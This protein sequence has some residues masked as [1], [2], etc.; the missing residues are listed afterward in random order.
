MQSKISVLAILKLMR[1][2][3]WIKN[4]FVLAPLIFAGLFTQI[5]SVI[6]ALIAML[7][8]CVGS[9]ATYVLNDFKDIENDKK[10]PTKSKTRPLAS[11][12]VS[13][14]QAKVLMVVLYGTVAAAYVWQPHIVLVIT[15]YLLLNIAYTFYL[16]YQPVLDIFTISIGFV[17]RV[18]AGA[19]ALNVPLSS[20]MFIT[21]L[22]LALYLAA[23]KR[24]QELA[25]SGEK[26]RSVLRYY[27][28]ELIDKY[29]E[30]SATCALLFYS[31]YVISD[32]PKMVFTIP[33]VL[34]GL[35]RYWYI[36][37]LNEEG[38]SPTDA[39]FRDTQIQLTI[40]SWIMVCG[41]ALSGI[42]L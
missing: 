36:V 31:L 32:Q 27:N 24:R 17:L 18:Y 29:A 3:Q 16:K 1:P 2:K 10:H 40:I 33:F 42:S 38:E 15:A 23:I 9:S 22:C 21:T 37:E 6:Q 26:A 11:G 4:S 28:A 30:M 19:V 13:K 34:F 39:L 8:F 7:L 35:F 25:K 20:W 5:E 14:S 12:D 41:Y